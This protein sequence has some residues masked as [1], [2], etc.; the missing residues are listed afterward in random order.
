[1][2]DVYGNGTDQSLADAHKDALTA[3]NNSWTETDKLYV[4]VCSALIALAAL[5]GHSASGQ[6]SPIPMAF[7]GILVLLLSVN[8][9]LLIMRYRGKILTALEG[10]ARKHSVSSVREY[11]D[12]ERRR[13]SNDWND[14]VVAIIVCALSLIIIVY[15][16]L[17]DKI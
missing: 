14:Y 6:H 16:I 10:L 8:W 3:A 5:F 11:Y 1:M 4:S 7:V 12:S 9:M 13:F 2:T 17:V 15:G